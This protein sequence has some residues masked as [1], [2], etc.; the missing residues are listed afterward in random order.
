MSDEEILE[1]LLELNLARAG[2]ASGTRPEVRG[3]RGQA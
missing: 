2:V 3:S 1:R